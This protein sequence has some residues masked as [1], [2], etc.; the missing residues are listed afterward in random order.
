MMP[1]KVNN[2]SIADELRKECQETIDCCD[3][4]YG[5][6]PHEGFLHLEHMRKAKEDAERILR[7]LDGK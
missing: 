7:A 2:V 6:R 5:N 3:G 4:N 1:C